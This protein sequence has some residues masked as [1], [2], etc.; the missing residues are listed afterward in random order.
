MYQVTINEELRCIAFT[1]QRNRSKAI[2]RSVTALSLRNHWRQG[3][4]EGFY[5][6][7]PGLP[8]IS[9]RMLLSVLPDRV[10]Y[11]AVAVVV[12][13]VEHCGSTLEWARDRTGG[14]KTS[15][16]DVRKP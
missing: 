2:S 10:L 4:R 14:G 7:A 6:D 1:C 5:V 3:S 12:A 11:F 15:I 9:R 16:R 8:E 13:G